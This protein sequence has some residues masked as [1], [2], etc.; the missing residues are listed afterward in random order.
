MRVV[1]GGEGEGIGG[2]S[3]LYLGDIVVL[4]RE[5]SLVRTNCR[6]LERLMWQAD[7][8][9]WIVVA[10]ACVF[11]GRPRVTSGRSTIAGRVCLLGI[12]LASN[13][14]W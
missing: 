12:L 8:D 6:G 2:A 7:M 5:S 13:W 10:R 1:M 4:G 3:A 11:E 14:S 9:G